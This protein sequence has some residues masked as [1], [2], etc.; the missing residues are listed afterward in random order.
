MDTGALHGPFKNKLH[1]AKVGFMY[2]KIS[3][4]VTRERKVDFV[5]RVYHNVTRRTKSLAGD[6]DYIQ[7][8]LDEYYAEY[9]VPF[10]LLQAWKAIKDC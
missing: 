7:K 9:G 3:S 6:V 5:R 10:T 1:C 8:T 2:S 4:L